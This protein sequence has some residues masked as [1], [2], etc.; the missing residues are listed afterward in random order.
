MRPVCCGRCAWRV[1]AGVALFVRHGRRAHRR[2]AFAPYSPQSWQTHAEAGFGRYGLCM[3]C[4]G[5]FGV[6]TFIYVGPL[7]QHARCGVRGNERVDHDG[8]FVGAR[9][10]PY[11]DRR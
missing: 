4:V 2:F 9:Y 7:W 1:A 8:L 6:H 10:R 5:S 11:V 3:A